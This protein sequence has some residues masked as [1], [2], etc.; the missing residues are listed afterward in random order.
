MKYSI[1]LLKYF[2]S[3][4]RNTHK[5][6]Y[7]TIWASILSF[8]KSLPSS[9]SVPD[10][11]W[12]LE[13]EI[14]VQRWRYTQGITR[15]QRRNTEF[16]E[17]GNKCVSGRRR[18]RKSSLMS[19]LS[20]GI[21]KGPTILVGLEL[22]GQMSCWTISRCLNLEGVFNARAVTGKALNFE[23]GRDVVRLASKRITLV[24]EWLEDECKRKQ[25]GNGPLETDPVIWKRDEGVNYGSEEG[26]ERRE[27][28]WEI[29][30]WQKKQDK[31]LMSGEGA[32]TDGEKGYVWP[33]DS[34]IIH[35]MIVVAPTETETLISP[36]SFWHNDMDYF[37]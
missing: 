33:P 13:G 8:H 29:F 3:G 18:S 20:W 23:Q 28:N 31:W 27:H 12:A 7:I 6:E 25:T 34:S 1:H 35:V 37:L 9:Y 24:P 14:M 30:R 15:V 26:M 16:L 11:R 4:Q 17:K 21:R 19:E 2:T 32:R 5:N 36:F 22:D 10:S